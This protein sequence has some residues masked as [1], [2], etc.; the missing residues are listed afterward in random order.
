MPAHRPP[1][2]AGGAL[3]FV[4]HRGRTF[5]FGGAC[6]FGGPCAYR[7]AWEW[8]G[9]DWTEVSAV[10][11]TFGRWGHRVVYDAARRRVVTFG[12]SDE[13]A[14]YYDDTWEWDGIAW[15][16]VVPARNVP[17]REAY[18]MAYDTRLAAVT[19]AGGV[20]WNGA[21]YSDVEAR[22]RRRVLRRHRG[23]R[24]PTRVETRGGTDESE[25]DWRRHD[26]R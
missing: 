23:E 8:D 16:Q 26:D 13:P 19:L 22:M 7:D 4:T 24:D 15:Q 20:G 18:A 21:V 2:R 17:G 1:P 3:T 5:L 14:H 25:G 11:P 12:G 9:V 6:P 10:F